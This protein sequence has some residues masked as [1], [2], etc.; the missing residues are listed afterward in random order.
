MEIDLSGVYKRI[1]DF[2]RKVRRWLMLN[3][4]LSIE[5]KYESRLKR[6]NI[7]FYNFVILVDILFLNVY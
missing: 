5:K 7:G 6:M 4:Y 2:R 3:K 1:S